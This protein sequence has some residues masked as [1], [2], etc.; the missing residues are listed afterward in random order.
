MLSQ[1]FDTGI[2]PS[3]QS[4]QKRLFEHK[5]SYFLCSPTQRTVGISGFQRHALE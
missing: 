5:I 1:C 3:M 2:Q 4:H